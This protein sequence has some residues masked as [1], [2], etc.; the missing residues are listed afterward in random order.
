MK[1]CVSR[2][3]LKKEIQ[4]KKR[5]NL[6]IASGDKSYLKKISTFTI[7]FGVAHKVTDFD[8]TGTFYKYV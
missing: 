4:S 8:L 5:E 1:G 6:K 2:L 7:R 3:V